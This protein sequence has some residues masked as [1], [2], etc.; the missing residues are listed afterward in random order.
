MV[1]IPKNAS[2]ACVRIT[3]ASRVAVAGCLDRIG[4]S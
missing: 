1:T 3:F 4:L 2:T